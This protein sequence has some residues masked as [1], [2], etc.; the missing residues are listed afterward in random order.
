MLL[1][2]KVSGVILLAISLVASCQRQNGAAAV[3][4]P[5]P[6]TRDNMDRE[7]ADVTPCGLTKP[8]KQS[9]WLSPDTCINWATWVDLGHLLQSIDRND[10]GNSVALLL[11]IR[12][13]RDTAVM[14]IT[15]DFMK[16][17][18]LNYYSESETLQH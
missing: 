14:L 13:K 15:H 3:K 4:R 18:L 2:I 9:G 7:Q 6:I 1:F 5:A 8:S 12:D 11:E 16:R 17:K 10:A